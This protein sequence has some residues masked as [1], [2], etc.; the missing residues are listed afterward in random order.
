[1]VFGMANASVV[2]VAQTPKNDKSDGTLDTS[3]RDN[4]INA[5]DVSSISQ[6]SDWV[7]W[8][9]VQA[10]QMLGLGRITTLMFGAHWV[11]QQSTSSDHDPVFLMCKTISRLF[12]SG[13]QMPA[14]FARCPAFF[15]ASGRLEERL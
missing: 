13:V 15:M 1:M 10:V 5:M 9:L 2:N 4:P 14:R 3:T 12:G 7:R 11:N 8:P 6:V